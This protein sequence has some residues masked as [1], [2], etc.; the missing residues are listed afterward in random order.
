MSDLNEMRRTLM[1]N[2][3]NVVLKERCYAEAIE[4][5]DNMTLKQLKS[6]IKIHPDTQQQI[7]GY[8]IA[9]AEQKFD[10]L[11]DVGGDKDE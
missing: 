2:A 4:E 10:N 6:V 8:T 3:A 1:S 11:P 7:D 9:K 5:V